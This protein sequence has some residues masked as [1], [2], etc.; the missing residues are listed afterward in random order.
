MIRKFGKKAIAT[1]LCVACCL[2]AA[3]CGT[4]TPGDGITYVPA[5]ALDV[6]QP[7][8]IIPGT[9][10]GEWP[11]APEIPAP[12]PAIAPYASA[13]GCKD[14]AYS[15]QAD[16]NAGAVT[17]LTVSY[18]DDSELKTWDYFYIDVANW[19]S[20]YSFFSFKFDNIAGA[21]QITVAVFY[22]E[23][24]TDGAP[25]V[26]V[27]LDTFMKSAEN[28]Y[29]DIS[30]FVTINSSYRLTDDALAAQNIIRIF[31]FADSNPAQNSDV[32]AGGFDM[33][34]SF[35][36]THPQQTRREG[37]PIKSASPNGS[38]YYTL[39]TNADG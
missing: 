14:G 17:S 39:G 32:S 3:A 28:Y 19:Q 7:L 31:F 34:V 12:N 21:K 10:I 22:D 20:E 11:A 36:K 16:T 29:I 1:V 26:P 33:S 5:D 30:G 27:L 25:L 9:A 37:E 15:L 6:P 2:A 4:A 35:G 38:A 18:G 24:Y 23:M 13:V 8:Q